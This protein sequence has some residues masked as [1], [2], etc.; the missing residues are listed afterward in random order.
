MPNELPK[1]RCL[2]RRMAGF[3]LIELL[4]VL[5]IIGILVGLLMPAVQAAR[6]ASRRA[7]CQNNL[8]Q[9]AVATHLYELA[10]REFPPG[11][12][13]QQFAV[14]PVYRGSSLFVYLVPHLENSSFQLSWNFADVTANTKGG[15]AAV[16]AV[17]L[18]GFICPSDVLEK[19]QVEQSQVIYALT[20]YGGNGGTRSYFPTDATTDGIFH[21]TGPASEPLQNQRPTR[22][23]EVTDGTSHTLLFGERYHADQNQEAFAQ[24][25]WTQSLMTWGWWAPAG[26]RKA[27]GHVTLSA[28]V[29][30]NYEI[31]FTPAAADRA[32]PPATDGVSFAYYGDLRICAFGS[33]HSGGAN[34]A[35]VDGSCRYIADAI[36][37]EMLRGLA[38]RSGQEQAATP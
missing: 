33:G 8:R 26:G 7:Q 25:G 37:L 24:A 11:V 35:L 1:L 6:E 9:L 18:P 36:S 14:A 22:E 34:F 30:I 19:S 27:I 4:V 32:N 23:Q 38:T 10:K 5:A 17:V 3:T 29:P 13:Q 31:P 28:V 2:R 12:E 16:T 15:Y 20:S 21:T